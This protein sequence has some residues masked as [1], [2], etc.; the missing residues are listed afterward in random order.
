MIAVFLFYGFAFLLM[1]LILGLQVR[2]P[3]T[4]LHALWLLAAFG[5]LHGAAE[6]AEL[7]GRIWGINHQGPSSIGAPR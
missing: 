4:S 1:G 5:L 2:S 6:W 7:G 3:W